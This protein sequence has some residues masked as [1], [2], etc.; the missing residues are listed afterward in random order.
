VK[1]KKIVELQNIVHG[2]SVTGGRSKM[3]LLDYIQSIAEKKKDR[4]A[5]EGRDARSSGYQQYMALHY[6][7]QQ[8]SGNKTT[9][10]QV[11][12]AYC[13]G[14]IEYLKTAKSALQDQV[15][16]NNTQVSYMKKFEYILNCAISDEVTNLNPF[17]QINPENKPQKRHTEVCFLTVDEVNTLTKTPHTLSPVMKQAFLF[18]CFSGLRFSDVKAL[19]W[20]K[21]QK[22]NE[23]NTFI[24]CIQKKTQKQEY[25]PVAQKAIQYLPERPATATG[26]DCV[27]KLPSGGYVNL[28]LKQWAIT[29]GITKHLTFHLTD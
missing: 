1:A 27:F 12:K 24:N 13:S 8:Y 21:L 20:E 29:A 18:S 16:S 5:K 3:N 15:L 9:F 23:G 6:H 10:K 19:T 26:N 22:D 14:F 28:H 17:K 2:F 25:L 7:I 4:A 11:D